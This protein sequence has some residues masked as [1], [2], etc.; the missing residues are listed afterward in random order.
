M[1]THTA[2]LER[3]ADGLDRVSA[4]THEL[5]ELRAEMA[6]VREATAVLGPMDARMATI[7]GAMPVLVE[8]Q[9]HL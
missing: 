7:E 2:M 9:Q 1:V 5:A 4:D 6:S 8:V 3:I